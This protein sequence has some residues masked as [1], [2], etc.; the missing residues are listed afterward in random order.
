MQQ[1]KNGSY[2][3]KFGIGLQEGSDA[4]VAANKIIEALGGDVLFLQKPSELLDFLVERG[5]IDLAESAARLAKIPDFIK[6]NVS[7]PKQG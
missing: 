6:F 4:Q 1:A 7:L 2:Y 5:D 3:I